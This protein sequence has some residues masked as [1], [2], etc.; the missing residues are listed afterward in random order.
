MD[1]IR[2]RKSNLP[3]SLHDSRI[4]E[5]EISESTLSLKIDRVFQY[6]DD[7]EKWFSGVI[8]FTKTDMEECNILVFNTPYG[9]DGE[10]SFSGNSLS[11]E[12]F[13]K[14]YPDAEFEIVTEGYCGYDTTYQGWIWQGENDPLFGIMSIWNMGDMIYR[15]ED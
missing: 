5:I 7:E 10:K 12:E 9:Y 6:T 15:I 11:L 8:D 3:F 1:Y 4:K 2:S 14:Q 13:K